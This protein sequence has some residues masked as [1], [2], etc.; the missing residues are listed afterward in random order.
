MRT[1]IYVDVL[2]VINLF[3]NWFLLRLTLHLCRRTPRPLRLLCGALGGGLFALVIL[4]E[5]LHWALSLFIRL[6]GAAAL[7]LIACPV[8]SP[9]EFFRCFLCF[10]AANFLFG[11][12]MFALETLLHPRG[13]VYQNGAVYFPLQLP[14]LMALTA[15]CYLLLTLILH[16]TRSAA[17]KKSL[18]EVTVEVQGRRCRQTALVDT[19][20]ALFDSFSGDPVILSEAATLKEILP[21]PVQNALRDGTW[22]TLRDPA[23]QKRL[24]LIPYQG[25]G[26]AGLLPAF[27]PDSVTVRIGENKTTTAAVL[28]GVSRTSLGSGVYTAIVH[29]LIIP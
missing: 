19:G 15:L 3:V 6:L 25:V 10:F 20:N 26:Q 18:C 2:I 22:E 23:W 21:E 9:R 4:L 24:R 12:G 16:I 27:R 5:P 1:V 17:P 28:V 14:T 29:P 11:G 8:K 13:M 7:V